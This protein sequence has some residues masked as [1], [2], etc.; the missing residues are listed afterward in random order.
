MHQIASPQTPV[1]EL[2]A[3]PRPDPLPVFRGLLLN[4]RKGGERRERNG[5][6][7]REEKEVGVY[8]VGYHSRLTDLITKTH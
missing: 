2:T 8:A 6:E 3:L 4:G 1:G 5:K 7:G